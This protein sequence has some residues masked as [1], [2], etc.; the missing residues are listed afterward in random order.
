MTTR[1]NKITIRVTPSLR[2][3][4]VSLYAVGRFGKTG[5]TISPTVENGVAL[6]PATDPKAYWTSVLTTAQAMIDA[7]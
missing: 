5:L 7:L 6:S 4:K 3:Q 1:P 2:A